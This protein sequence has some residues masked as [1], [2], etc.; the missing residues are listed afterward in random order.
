MATM[1][2]RDFLKTAAATAAALAFAPRRLFAE[3]GA[4]A[5]RVVVAHGT[6]IPRMLAAGIAALGGWG[7]FVRPGQKAT[8]KPNAGWASTPEQGANTHPQLVEEAIRAIRVAG[9]SEVVLPENPCS[10][11]ARSFAM[12]GI[13]AAAKNAGG[14][15]YE[16]DDDKDFV[17]VAVPGGKTLKQVA[18]VRDVL[19]TGC[20]INVPVAK[21]HGGAKLTLGLKNWMGS[22]RDRGF[23]HRNGLHQ[24]IADFATLVKARLTI[25]D[26]TRIMVT[27]GPRGPG[28]LKMPNQLVFGTDPVAVDAY[29]ATLFGM[30]PFAV[31]HIQIAHDMGLGCG[32]L[33][34]VDVQHLEA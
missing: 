15:L 6:D 5:A 7:A 3:A 29:A 26:A 14:R 25:V 2:R 18:V 16:P 11:A 12:S 28:E 22:V 24:C 1:P 34:K 4:S 10:P 13:G 33:A 30:Q 27:N 32:D 20:L 17:E 31:P 23:W 19:E 21:S 8:L 9:A